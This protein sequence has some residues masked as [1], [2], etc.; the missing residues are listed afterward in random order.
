MISDQ[1]SP[2]CVKARRC[3]K[4]KFIYVYMCSLVISYSHD[5]LMTFTTMLVN[6]C[7]IRALCALVAGN[8]Y[9]VL[10]YL[11]V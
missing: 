5:F 2:T 9:S 10:I 4:V 11:P 3:L 7:Y 1:L 6:I 8:E